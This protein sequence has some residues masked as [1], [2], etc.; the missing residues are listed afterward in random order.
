V[1]VLN[2][3][4]FLGGSQLQVPGIRWATEAGFD[5]YLVDR[6]QNAAGQR[7][8]KEFFC[9]DV[10]DW[11]EIYHQLDITGNL[12][13]IHCIY[14]S[15]DF[16]LQTVAH[17]NEALGLKGVNKAQASL[18]LD[19]DATNRQLEA[20]GVKVPKILGRL[21]PQ[22]FDFENIKYPVVVKPSIGSGSVGVTV[23]ISPDELEP[24]MDVAK[25]LGGVPII[26]EY[27]EGTHIDVSGFVLGGTFRRGGLLVRFFTGG[28]KRVP[29]WGHQPSLVSSQQESEI[30]SQLELAAHILGLKNTPLKADIVLTQ[31][32]PCLIEVSARFHGDV[33]SSFVAPRAY[34]LS[35]LQNWFGALRGLKVDYEGF[36]KLPKK[37]QGWA[38]ILSGRIGTLLAVSGI[39]EASETTG[40]QEVLIRRLP[41]HHIDS[42]DDNR[43]VI[44]FIFAEAGTPDALGKILDTAINR[45]QLEF[46]GPTP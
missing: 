6:E 22:I 44:G 31:D 18:L 37:L 5:V 20:R 19:K 42:T 33:S 45:I 16:G 34:G 12:K 10:C 39:A 3:L 15:S 1:R 27:V 4:L 23:A 14:A 21:T 40:V 24:A 36:D 29:T 43:A 7:F 11:D 13:K 38:A 26:E 9:V 8:A 28:A 30:Y 46:G 32:G 2:G 35:P 41:G 25:R 17:L